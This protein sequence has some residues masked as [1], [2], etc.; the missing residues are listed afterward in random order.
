MGNRSVRIDNHFSGVHSGNEIRHGGVSQGC[1]LV[2]A[3]HG[4]QL[5][6]DLAFLVL[7]GLNEL[8]N[9]IDLVGSSVLRAFQFKELFQFMLTVSGI[10]FQRKKCVQLLRSDVFNAQEF[11][12]LREFGFGVG[13]IVLQPFQL[14]Q[15]LFLEAADVQRL[16]NGPVSGDRIA[17]ICG[18]LLD[19][20][21]IRRRDFP[22]VKLLGNGTVRIDYYVSGGH[23]RY[24][25]F[26]AGIAHAGHGGV[27]EADQPE[28][29]FQRSGISGNSTGE[30]PDLLNHFRRDLIHAHQLKGLLQRFVCGFGIR[31][32]INEPLH[33]LVRDIVRSGKL[34]G[35][36]QF[37][38]L[39]DHLSLQLIDELQI[40]FGDVSDIQLGFEFYF[41]FRL[42]N[43]VCQ[44]AVFLCQVNDVLLFLGLLV[45]LIEPGVQ[46]FKGWIRFSDGA[47]QCADPGHKST[48]T[49]SNSQDDT[50]SGNGSGKQQVG[51]CRQLRDRGISCHYTGGYTEH[52]D[53]G[54]NALHDGRV[55]FDKLSDG[56]QEARKPFCHGGNHGR[57]RISDGDL[58]VVRRV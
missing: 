29:L 41:R 2:N 15:I 44:L 12:L 21:Q 45:Q 6:V 11:K 16:G 40:L 54:R 33:V 46:R 58:H 30:V 18:Y 56:L 55:L 51:S 52:T 22:Q 23:V 7:N 9:L 1:D 49:G 3:D 53:K 35:L 39:I 42:G 14:L 38:C 48:D 37:S 27:I 32:Q 4:F 43:I 28:L 5:L 34:E 24:K 19:Q 50:E 17:V 36:L 10:D 13:D 20:F 57:Q 25:V 8:L 31:G 47:D 26:V